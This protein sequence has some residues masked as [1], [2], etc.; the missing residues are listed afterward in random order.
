MRCMSSKCD[1]MYMFRM[2]IGVRGLL[3]IIM[4]WRYGD[5]GLGVGILV[6]FLFVYINFGIIA[7][8]PTL[9]CVG[10]EYLL[11]FCVMFVGFVVYNYTFL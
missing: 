1:G 9:A 5:I 8:M 4:A 6:I 10:P 3:L 7:S 2:S 11:C